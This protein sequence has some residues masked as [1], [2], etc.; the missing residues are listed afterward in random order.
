MS[1]CRS[2]RSSRYS[3]ASPANSASALISPAFVRICLTSQSREDGSVRVLLPLPDRDFDVTEVAVPWAILREA[4]HQ[5]VFATEK[6]GTIPAADPRLLTGVLFGQ[7]G[8][9]A[10]ARKLYYELIGTP[11][12]GSTMAWADLES[13]PVRRADPARRAR[14]GHAAI[15]RLAGAQGA[16]RPVL[17]AEPAGR[18]DLPRR[19]GAG[20]H[21]RPGHRPQ[22]AGRP[23]TTCLPK[24]MERWPTWSPRWRLGR[25]YRTYPAC[26]DLRGRGARRPRPGRP[27][28]AWPGHAVRARTPPPA[29]V[30]PSSCATVTT[31]RPAGRATRTCSAARFATCSNLRDLDAERTGL[32]AL[33]TGTRLADAPHPRF[34]EAP[35]VTVAEG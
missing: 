10:E 8:A 1:G 27:V 7:L 6:A 11:E 25:Y 15:P 3:R 12:F 2:A 5:V 30:P 31:C 20:A 24:Y 28:R 29:T 35:T 33:I 9:A 22:R 34:Q 19:A 4:G 18:R 23:S 14:S 32:S 21:P 16:S 17:A 13:R 26:S